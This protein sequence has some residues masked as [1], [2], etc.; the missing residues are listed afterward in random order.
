MAKVNAGSFGKRKLKDG[1]WTYRLRFNVRG[2][3]EI[4]VLHERAG[5]ACGCGGGWTEQGA[6]TELGNIL[7][8]VRAGVWQASKPPATLRATEQPDGARMTFHEYASRWLQ[9][10][11]EG[12]L[13]D[14]PIDRSTQA[15]YRWRLSCH[16]L[17][18]FATYTLAQIDAELC[19]EF[20]AHKLREAQELRA[21]IEAGADI[22]DQRGRRR[23]PL[24]PASMRK[25][26]DALA[27]ILDEAIEDGYLEHNPARGRRMKIKVPK[28]KRTFLELDELACL[29]EE[30]AEQDR[31]VREPEPA[32]NLGLTAAMVA[33]LLAQDKRP[34][35]I[36]E[37][38]KLA[39]STVSF[40]VG[41]LNANV[42]RGY[43]GRRVVCEILGRSGVRASEL[44]DIKIGHMRLHGRDGA[45]FDIPDA[46]TEK[47]IREVQMTP[48]LAEAVSEHIERLRR[49]G[50]NTGPEAYLVP[51]LKGGRMARQRVGEIVTEAAERASKRLTAEG[52]PPLQRTTP[53]SLRRTYISI[54]LI[55]NNFDVKWVMSQVGHADSKMTMDVYAQLEQRMDRSHGTNFD[56]LLNEARNRQPS[57]QEAGYDAPEEPAKAPK[58]P[59]KPI[60]KVPKRY[61]P[62]KRAI[63]DPKTA[64]QKNSKTAPE[65][66]KNPMARPGLEPGTPRFSVVCS[67]N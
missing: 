18:F 46:K 41:R 39:K 16:L 2:R 51:N 37:Q 58:A 55:A 6:R 44:C 29:L 12:V 50:A 66:A 60:Q 40:H 52:L 19:L 34:G 54:A 25:L 63:C 64:A 10:K 5:C 15:D 1:T 21:A 14:A 24:G 26:I 61:R 57:E 47:G 4:V 36:A 49:I 28:P 38:L 23:V 3:R 27:A 67:T 45:R 59:Q 8:R 43:V 7:A 31:P 62:P 33:R 20:K 13:G 11:V 65:Q 32:A 22:R 17:P 30:A 42:G 56:R 48:D 9:G 53:H 35:E